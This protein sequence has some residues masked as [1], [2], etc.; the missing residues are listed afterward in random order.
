M[1]Y[2]LNQE[3]QEGDFCGSVQHKYRV[4]GVYWAPLE[5]LRKYLIQLA[6]VGFLFFYLI[7]SQISVHSKVPG[8]LARSQILAHI[9]GEALESAFQRA[10]TLMPHFEEQVFICSEMIPFPWHLPF[11]SLAVDEHC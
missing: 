5:V 10:M 8:G 4:A 11:I 6:G 9:C 3:A 2:L 1:I 7:A